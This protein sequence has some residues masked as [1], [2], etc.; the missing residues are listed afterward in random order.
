[1]MKSF[2]FIY[3]RRVLCALSLGIIAASAQAAYPDRPITINVPAAPG[4]T[5][6]IV[7]RLL[8]EQIA[9]FLGQSAVVMNR[10]GAGGVLG[11]QFMLRE[12]PDGYSLLV[13]ANS[14]QLIVPWVFKNAKFDPIK[15][16]VPIAAVGIVSN[17]LC[18]HPSFPAKDLKSFIAEVKANPN[19]YQ[20][21]S[22]GSGTLNHLLGEML[23]EKG[24][25]KLQHV[26]YKGVGPAMN[27]VMGN[28]IPM[29]F[30]SL[31][32][33]LDAIKT[34]KVRAIGV[35]S[36]ARDPLLPEV[37]AIGE[38]IL[39]F[40]GD[41]WVAL[42]APKGTALEIV[43]R[44][45]EAVRVSL[46]SP[47]LQQRF[48]SLGITVLHDGPKELDNRQKSE[49]LQWKKIVEASGVTAN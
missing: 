9:K 7:A 22:A 26:S 17:V 13:T 46:A 20:Y 21:A 48:K 19:K 28:H 33:A 38:Q 10:P 29:L 15:D 11:T 24:G 8:S 49:Y 34:G 23:N 31:P 25:L 43:H 37:P 2:A 6:D 1:M 36:L 5:V 35:S 16:F 39:G 27:D 14:N 40:N 41:L 18:V 3:A 42:Y 30:A 47:A 32:S 12:A 4:G 45:H 44:L